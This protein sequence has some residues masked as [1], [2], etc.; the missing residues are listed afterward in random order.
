MIYTRK[1]NLLFNI[2]HKSIGRFIYPIRLYLYW[3]KLPSKIKKIREKKNIKVLFIGSSLGMWK[4]EMLYLSM[5]SNPRFSPII[6]IL[7]STK[8]EY[9]KKDYLQYLQEKKY[10]YVDLDQ[11]NYQIGKINP[12]II[13]YDSPY[14]SE[15]PRSLQFIKNLSYVFCGVDYCLNITKH[16]QHLCHPWY[17]Y[18]WQFYVEHDDVKRRKVELLGYR[19]RNIKVTGVPIQDSLT[20]PRGVFVD[21]WKDKTAKKRV[22]YA[23]HHSFKGSN[24]E[25]IEFATFLENG[26][27]IL[28]L[29]EKYKDTVTCAFKPHPFLYIKLLNVWGKEK[30]DKYYD[31]WKSLP[32]TQFENCDY[33]GLFKYSDAIIHD[34][35]SFIIEYMY[36]DKQAMFLMSESNKLDEMFG[37]V[38]G[39]LDCHEH[40]YNINDVETFIVNVV[41]NNDCKKNVRS[42]YIKAE[43]LPPN[44]KTACENIINAILFNE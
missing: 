2:L 27:A 16:K 32:N 24:G 38:R 20:Q 5:S 37:Y 25:G 6:G 23:P 29:A 30:T 34:S 43:L 19:A 26:E 11:I 22:I 35:A 39:A 17:D 36:M 3:Y 9:A 13:F 42:E 40:G 1:R 12:D 7:S 28:A 33:L 31:T 41:N 14:L 4:T 10:S 44:G 18:C 21:P 8:Y 15:Y